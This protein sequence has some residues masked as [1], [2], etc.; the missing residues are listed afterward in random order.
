MRTLALTLVVGAAVAGAL[1]LV[2]NGF[3]S[4]FAAGV[5]YMLIASVTINTRAGRA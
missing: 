2:T 3:L 1:S 5:S 4:G